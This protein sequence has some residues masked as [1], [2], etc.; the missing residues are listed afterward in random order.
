[1][2]NVK[3]IKSN[4]TKTQSLGDNLHEMSKLFSGKKNKKNIV[5][6]SSAELAQSVVQVKSAH[7]RDYKWLEIWTFCHL[8]S[9][10]WV[11][12]WFNP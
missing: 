2:E 7:R 6:L 4:P 8:S 12:M 1:M 3:T 11:K 10:L 5:N 9:R